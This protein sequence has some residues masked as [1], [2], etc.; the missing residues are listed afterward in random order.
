MDDRWVH[1]EKS[2]TS[3]IRTIYRLPS[4]FWDF[5]RLVIWLILVI[6]H[7]YC[8]FTFLALWVKWVSGRGRGDTQSDSTNARDGGAS[9]SAIYNKNDS[10][11]AGGEYGAT[12]VRHSS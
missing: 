7:I 8:L 6:T 12:G 10:I 3:R 4:D 5:L 9:Q 1:D 2:G 11:R